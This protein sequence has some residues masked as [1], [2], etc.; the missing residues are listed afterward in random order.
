M[1]T[2]TLLTISALFVAT[3]QADEM[4]IKQEGIKYIKMLGKEL[5]TNLKL[6][7]KADPT[8]IQAMAFCTAK[9]GAITDEINSKLPKNAKVRRT[10]FEDHFIIEDNGTG[11][12][13]NKIKDIDGNEKYSCE[14]AWGSMRAGSNFDD[15]KRISAGA[16]G[17]GSFLTNVFSKVF[18][19]EN[20]NSGLK[21]TCKWEDNTE[22]YEKSE[23]K[24]STSG[25]KVVAYPDFER[26]S[27]KGFRESEINMIKTRVVM[28]ALTYPEIKFIFNKEVIK[29]KDIDF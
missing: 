18:I 16:N 29:A 27:V 3:L 12:P 17:V 19:G 21:V 9:A 7:L 24:I 26:F 2:I 1:K 8:G 4:A 6:H 22:K 28:L 14:V 11:I 5:K 13:N 23:Q 20:K 10:M 15:S 25:V